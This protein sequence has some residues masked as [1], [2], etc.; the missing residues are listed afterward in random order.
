MWWFSVG[1][2]CSISK[3]EEDNCFKVGMA[4]VNRLWLLVSL[5]PEAQW[6]DPDDR[7][8]G[9]TPHCRAFL[10]WAVPVHTSL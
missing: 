9:F 3:P 5:I 6:M 4:R 10:S 7:L 8:V 1:D 2:E